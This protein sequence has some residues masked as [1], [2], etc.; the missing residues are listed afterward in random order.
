VDIEFFKNIRLEGEESA[1]IEIR[2]Y[3]LSNS[4]LTMNRGFYTG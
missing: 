2:K 1:G 4:F 3:L